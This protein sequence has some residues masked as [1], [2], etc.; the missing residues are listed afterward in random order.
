[1]NEHSENSVWVLT[2]DR[3]GNRTQ[4]IGLAE[5]LGMTYDVKALR[6]GLRSQMH[7]LL[8]GASVAGVKSA[9]QSKLQ[10]PW[11]RLVI[12]A[13]RRTGPVARWVKAQSG[14]R[15][16]IVLLGRKGGQDPRPFDAVVTPVHA[17]LPAHPKRVETMGPL[18]RVSDQALDTAAAGAN[19]FE[20]LPKP[21]VALLVGGATAR[22]LFGPKEASILGTEVATAVAGT[23]GALIAVT[24]P[25]TG[26]TATESLTAVVGEQG[27]VL[28]WRPNDPANP[29]LSCLAHGDIL[30]VTGDSESMI[31]EAAAT[32]KAA[33]IY[34]LAANPVSRWLRLG[35]YVSRQAA[36]W[37]AG[38]GGLMPRLCGTLIESGLVR[39]PRD[40]NLMHTALESMEYVKIFDGSLSDRPPAARFR[41]TEHVAETL[42]AMLKLDRL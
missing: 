26:A 14:R 39:P 28:A 40:L 29:Y 32:G 19:P 10:P 35:G 23:K 24:S 2:D 33:Y 15:T 16:K 17:G 11:P 1:L 31:A 22:Q 8:L 38:Q 30:V 12:A 21:W 13:G 42:R 36:L 4:A 18:N 25:R 9:D 5:A 7:N 20:G 27:Q 37:R 34:Q 3:A 6:F 41:E